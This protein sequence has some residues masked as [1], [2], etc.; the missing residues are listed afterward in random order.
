MG[1]CWDTFL[2]SNGFSTTVL[3]VNP[4][5]GEPLI[6]NQLGISRNGPDSLNIH[7][8][9][10][11][12]PSKPSS[13]KKNVELEVIEPLMPKIDT[14]PN[15]M[16]DVEK[17]CK[18]TKKKCT[19]LGFQNKKLGHLISR[20]LKNQNN[21]HLSSISLIEVDEVSDSE[22]EYFLDLEDPNCQGYRKKVIVPT[23]P[24]DFVKNFPPCLKGEEGFFGIG[25]D[26][27]KII[28]KVD[29]SMFYCT[30][31]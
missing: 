18:Q 7:P 8:L 28:D 11:A 26:Q 23:K 20:K 24:Y 1:D 9:Y 21:A 3:V 13:E 5:L 19:D 4:N 10:V 15:V 12:M 17:P 30:L 2:I 14:S 25:L 6:K 16:L 31:H 29:T 27:G 22:T